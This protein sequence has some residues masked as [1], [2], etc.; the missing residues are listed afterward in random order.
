MI[1]DSYFDRF[2]TKK[3]RSP[4][5]LQ[6]ALIR[7]FVE[8]LHSLVLSSMPIASVL[9]IGC[10]EGFLSGYLS[11]KLTHVSFTG[12]DLSE[13]DVEALKGKF[14]RIEA[15]VGSAYD[16]SFLGERE[17]DLVICAEVLEHLETP[18]V[19]LDQMIARHPKRVI[20][21]V[22]NEP[23][24][25]AA[26]FL[27]GKNITRLGNDIEHINHFNPRSFRKLLEPR[28]DVLEVTTSFPWLLTLNAPR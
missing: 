8:R 26:N 24:F 16:L 15:H 25:M 11:E 10:G 2:A 13:E 14:P 6:R 22:P 19:A 9:E 12:V 3:Y 7:R 18:E 21:T 17:F 1:P 20:L 5:P 27:R 28:F 23:L 4:N